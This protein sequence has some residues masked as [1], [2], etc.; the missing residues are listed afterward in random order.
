MNCLGPKYTQDVPETYE[1]YR[2]LRSTGTGLLCAPRTKVIQHFYYA[3][4]LWNKLPEYPT[5]AKTVS[6]SKSGLK[7]IVYCSILINVTFIFFFSDPFAKHVLSRMMLG[8]NLIILDFFIIYSYLVFL[9]VMLSMSYVKHFQLFCKWNAVGNSTCPTLPVTKWRQPVN[10]VKLI[11]NLTTETLLYSWFFLFLF[12]YIQKKWMIMYTVHFIT[13][14]T[15]VHWWQFA[16]TGCEE[17]Q[18]TGCW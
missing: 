9:C 12:C 18:S 14:Y 4:H 17:K 2:P 8:F 15:T 1:A 3:P 7:N 11:P 13:K 5:S 10:W 16:I 6:S